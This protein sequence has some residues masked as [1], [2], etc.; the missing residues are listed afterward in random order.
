MSRI[1]AVLFAS[2]ALIVA[3]TSGAV[4]HGAPDEGGTSAGDGFGWGTGQVVADDGFGWVT[5]Q[6]VADD[7]FGWVTPQGGTDTGQGAGT[8][9]MV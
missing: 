3:V 7:G 4:F 6:V 1:A 2:A 5:G 8:G 9:L